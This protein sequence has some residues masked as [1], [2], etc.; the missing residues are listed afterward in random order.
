MGKKRRGILKNEMPVPLADEKFHL[1]V[2]PLESVYNRKCLLALS[3]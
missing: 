3:V 1:I 2:Y